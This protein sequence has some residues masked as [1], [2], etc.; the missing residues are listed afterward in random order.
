M[1]NIM[2]H[3]FET[4]KGL[5]SSLKVGKLFHK[6]PGG[7]YVKLVSHTTCH[8]YSTAVGTQQS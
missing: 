1:I 6:G 4:H 3:T 7:E 5:F 2:R 8:N